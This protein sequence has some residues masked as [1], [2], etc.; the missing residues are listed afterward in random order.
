[1]Y[2]KIIN[3][4]KPEMDKTIGFFDRE[5][6]KIRTSRA[7]PS[8]IEDV[9][10]DCFGQRFSLKQLAT[11]SIS[12]PREISIQPWDNSYIEGIISALRNSRGVI[13]A[14]PIVDKD[15]IRITLPSLSEEYRKNLLRVISDKQEEAKITIRRWRE[16]VWKEIQEGFKEG[17]IREDDK[18][19]AKDELQD[20]IDEYNEKIENIGERKKKEIYV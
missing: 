15:I 11:I 2:Q 18:F 10:V 19:R 3:K 9:I 16:Q 6:M 8:L 7:N 5:L 12:G 4:V 20:L 1:M 13:G 17:I 14:S